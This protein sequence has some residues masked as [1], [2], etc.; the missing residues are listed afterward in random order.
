MFIASLNDTVTSPDGDIYFILTLRLYAI[1]ALSYFGRVI[2]C[3][4]YIVG[5]G[6]KGSTVILKEYALERG[7]GLSSEITT[8]IM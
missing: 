5:D 4:T 2:F 8:V 3:G 1:F 7:L 6:G